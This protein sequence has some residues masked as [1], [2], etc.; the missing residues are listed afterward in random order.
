MSVKEPI[1][2]E[3]VTQLSQEEG[4][5]DREISEILKCHR[6]TITRIRT[7]H[8]IPRPNLRNR[9]DKVQVCKRCNKEDILRR[10]QRIKKY[11]KDCQKIRDDERRENKRLYM[12]MKQK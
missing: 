7:R 3:I 9:R 11:C 8:N 6:V 5:M 12:Q 4:M 10:K 1:S 2:V